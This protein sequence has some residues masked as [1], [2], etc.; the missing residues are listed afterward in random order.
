MLIH[1]FR[2]PGRI[3]GCTRD[4]AGDNLPA[5]FAPWTRFK[6][7]EMTRGEALPGLNV[8]ECLDDVQAF[9]FHVTDAHVRITHQVTGGEP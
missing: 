3:F 4:S 8:D 1:I 5:R 7:L 9:G 2:G 6:T